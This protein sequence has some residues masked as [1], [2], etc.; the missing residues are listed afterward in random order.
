ME[1]PL[2]KVVFEVP[3]DAITAEHVEPAL[4]ELL[5]DTQRK[6]DAIADAPATYVQTLGALEEATESLEFAMTVVDHLESVA[7][8]DALRAAYNKTRPRVSAFFSSL[9][10][11][12][13][14]YKAI[15]QFSQTDEASSLDPTKKRFLKKTLDDFRR[16]GAELSPDQKQKLSKIDVALSEATTRF[17]QNVLDETNAFELVITDPG[18]LAGLPD[19]AIEAARA[20]AESKGLDGYRFTLHAPSLTPLLTYLDDGTTREHVWRAYST[21]ATSG[22]RDNSQLIVDIIDLRRQKAEL[23]GYHDF[24]DLVLEDRMAKD[25]QTASRFVQDLVTKTRATFEQENAALQAFA[26]SHDGVDSLNPWDVAYY[27]EKQRKAL[28]DFD[29]EAL[30]PYFSLQRVL[31]GM[32]SLVQSLYGIEIVPWEAPTWHPDVR[33]YAIKEGDAFIAAFYADLFP[34]ED[35]RGGAWMNAFITGLPDPASPHLGLIC[36]NVNPATG[37]KPALLTHREVETLFHEFGHLLHHCL[38]RV[39]VRSLAGTNVAW[40]FV[41]LPS[42]IM[43]NWCWEREA[44]N[45]FASHYQSGEPIPDALFDKMKRA[46]TYRAANAQMRQLGFA[47]ADLA[48]HREYDHNKNGDV[49]CYAR[50]ILQAHA[51]T[52]LPDDYAMIAGFGHLFAS[53][54]GYAAGYYSYKWAEVLDADA[55]QRFKDEGIID[56]NVG[57]AF[58]ESVLEK[59]DSEDAAKL[60]RDFMGRDPD[61]NALLVRA[62]LAA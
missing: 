57:R 26:K 23:L 29:E 54:T 33:T 49:L 50:Q 58:R 27:A 22:P 3:F 12:E 17:S 8:T 16:H 35:K 38:T 55:F 18:K 44:L 25:G 20:N 9:S 6:V 36:A 42:Q 37:D 48:L 15:K 59:G 4:T 47:T 52:T 30:R 41:E 53:P 60:F 32:F 19:S 40:D 7:T 43:E 62:G 11:N 1:N 56:R 61:L 5:A 46:R 14:L 13:A 28:Y 45:R 39:G 2:A 24:S 31:D 34:R 10:M 21:R 51:P